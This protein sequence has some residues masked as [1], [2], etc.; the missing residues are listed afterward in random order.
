MRR[1]QFFVLA[2]CSL[3]SNADAQAEKG[4]FHRVTDAG[5]TYADIADH[6]YGHR[7]LERHL[8][9]FN[10]RPEPLREGTTIIIPTFELVVLKKNQSMADFAA[11][12]LSDPGRAEYLAELHNLRGKDRK[13]PKPAGRRFKVVPSLKHVAKRGET[14]ES[15]ANLYY[16]DVGQRRLRLLMLYNKMPNEAVKNGAAIRI[17]LDS[18]EFNRNNVAFRAKETFSIKKAIAEAPPP[19][20]PPPPPPRSI[21]SGGLPPP[22]VTKAKPPRNL[23]EDLEHAERLYGDGDYESSA[24]VA[25]RALA[26]ES[27]RAR[28]RVELLR[29]LAYAQI[30]LGD[31]QASRS[32]FKKLLELEPK[33]QLDLYQTSPKILDIFE[34]VALR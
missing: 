24:K 1:S 7:Y 30:A 11:E 21:A 22:A 19:R 20:E 16:R 2:L 33:Y 10:R 3:W 5:E 18:Q 26:D 6:Y 31:F 29:V 17:P 12:H 4:V 28:H 9:L 13:L 34:A 25:E 27:G 32:T 15:I 14:L 8:R 23:A